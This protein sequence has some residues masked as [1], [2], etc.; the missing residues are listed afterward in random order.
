MILFPRLSRWFSTTGLIIMCFS[1]AMGSFSTNVTH[2]VLSQGIGF[3]V[4]GCIAYSPSILFMPEWFDKKRGLAF[5]VVWAGSGLSGI[6]FPIVLE[7]LLGQFGFR[8]TLRILSGVL[9][10]L[11][12]PF[13]YFHKPRVPIQKGVAHRRLTTRFLYNRV[14]MIYQLVNVFEALG[15]F[16]PGIYLPSFARYIGFSKFLSSLTVT[17]LNMASIFGSISMGFLSDRCDAL[18][19]VSISTIG[20]VLSVFLLWGFSTKIPVL[21][22]FC[23]AYG[24]FAGS[25]SAIWSAMIREVQKVDSSAD[26]TIIFSAIAFGR[27]VGNVASG[28]FSEMLIKVDN[29]QGHARGAYGS[30]YGLIIVCTGL[31]SFMGAL[32][33]IGRLYKFI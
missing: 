20:T 19:C 1:L 16:L 27:G 2:L 12:L 28:P 26:T 21:L 14:F 25:F 7:R 29:W 11:P 15:F 30:G 31:T 24:I 33:W 5:G 4:G 9:F 13:L 23:V 10:V 6:L 17:V 3:G 18:T 8:T 22:V 32:C